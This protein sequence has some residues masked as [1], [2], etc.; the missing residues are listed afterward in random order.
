MEK[1]CISQLAS[2]HR[3]VEL[4]LISGSEKIQQ[5]EATGG[6]E[7]GLF[8]LKLTG[9]LCFVAVKIDIIIRVLSLSVFYLTVYS[10]SANC[11]LVCQLSLHLQ[12]YK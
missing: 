1:T 10:G 5:P 12:L 6:A 2:S 11:F 7:K 9:Q 3:T 4:S 8:A